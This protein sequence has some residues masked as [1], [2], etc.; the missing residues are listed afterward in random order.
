ME[1]RLEICRKKC[2]DIPEKGERN[3][4]ILE[5]Q[6]LQN[7]TLNGQE[8]REAGLAQTKGNPMWLVLVI[9]AV[10]LFACSAALIVSGEPLPYI[11]LVGSASFVLWLYGDVYLARGIP[12]DLQEVLIDDTG[13]QMRS[14][15]GKRRV[16]F[17]KTSGLYETETM[18][19][20]KRRGSRMIPIPKAALQ[21]GALSALRVH[22]EELTG[23]KWVTVKPWGKERIV[24]AA[25]AVV[26]G[27]GLLIG[28]GVAEDVQRNKLKEFQKENYSIALPAVFQ[29][30][31]HD[32]DF[33]YELQS[34]DVAVSVEC[35]TPQKGHPAGL[36]FG[37]SADK[38]MN[39]ALKQW[40][41]TAE[42][43]AELD[44]GSCCAFYTWVAD[45]GT[46]LFTC[47]AVQYADDAY[48]ITQL[49]CSADLREKYEPQL[50]QWA[51]SIRI[52]AE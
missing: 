44:N 25:V 16:P 4:E 28:S 8:K 49:T 31:E 18:L 1:E 9:A 32:P 23:K 17:A 47:V 7:Y 22:L 48:W 26:V 19:V 6:I 24:L 43:T 13:V 41:V 27:V 15:V 37:M 45:D 29:E 30:S 40:E 36:S 42:R 34:G 11:S 14:I 38:W 5:K 3:E 46:S 12:T 35:I 20:V 2:Y 21:P 33:F 10:V 51:E 50:T 52:T 39:W